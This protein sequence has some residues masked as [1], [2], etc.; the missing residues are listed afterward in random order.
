M[1][2]MQRHHTDPQNPRRRARSENLGIYCET[3]RFRPQQF[4]LWRRVFG[5]TGSGLVHPTPNM[6]RGFV[7]VAWACPREAS[8]LAI[9]S[10]PG[11]GPR[12]RT[13]ATGARPAPPSGRTGR[14]FADGGACGVFWPVSL[15]PHRMNSGDRRI[16]TCCTSK[17]GITTIWCEIL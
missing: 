7:P 16:C 17:G 3:F 1:R 13:R 14:Q 8:E 10:W 4:V 9:G 15:A 5:R 11:I 6:V 2:R 12:S